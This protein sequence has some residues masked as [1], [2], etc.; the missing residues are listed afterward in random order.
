MINIIILRFHS[1]KF[2]GQQYIDTVMKHKLPQ[3]IFG[4]LKH[5]KQCISFI[6]NTNGLKYT[7]YVSFYCSLMQNSYRQPLSGTGC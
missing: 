5:D 2:H 1:W 6:K 4:A 7:L 3:V